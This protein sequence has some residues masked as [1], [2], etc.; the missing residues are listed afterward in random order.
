MAHVANWFLTQTGDFNVFYHSVGATPI[1][2]QVSNVTA[3]LTHF[4]RSIVEKDTLK[5]QFEIQVPQDIKSITIPVTQ[6]AT[7]EVVICIIDFTNPDYVSFGTHKQKN[8]VQYSYR[9]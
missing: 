2:W 1:S 8:S 5:E 9:K 6:E 3:R 7:E 4:C